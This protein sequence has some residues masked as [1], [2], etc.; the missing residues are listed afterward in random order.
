MPGFEKLWIWKEAHQLMA[1][2]HEIA[3]NLPKDEKFRKRDQIERSSSS[4]PDNIAESYNSYYYNDKIKSLYVARKEAGE[5][6]NHLRALETKRYVTPQR[7]QNLIDRYER[8]I[9]GINSYRNYISE[10]RDRDNKKGER[11]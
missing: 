5:T 10:K 6:Q 3:K 8:V 7:S 1:E 4:V 11:P 9:A 2:I